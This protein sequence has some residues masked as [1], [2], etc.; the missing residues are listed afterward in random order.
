M[1]LALPTD[2][3]QS[4]ETMETPSTISSVHTP[5]TCCRDEDLA[6]EGSSEFDAIIC[7]RFASDLPM[8][9][10]HPL[11]AST[12]Q[13]YQPYPS[14]MAPTMLATNFYEILGHNGIGIATKN[15]DLA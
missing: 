1:E 6:I 12:A 5:P 13:P 3:A 7:G 4:I 8:H 14:Y 2:V 11:Y 15:L 9:L 10:E